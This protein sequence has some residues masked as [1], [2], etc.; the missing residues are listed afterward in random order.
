MSVDL[1]NRLRQQG[2]TI[3]DVC[4]VIVEF[5]L[6]K[7]ADLEKELNLKYGYPWNDSQDYRVIV[8]A[9]KESYKNKSRVWNGREFTKEDTILGGKIAGKKNL[10]S[11]H[12]HSIIN[13][14]AGGRASCQKE[15]TCPHCGKV[16]K[17]PSMFGWH[18]DKCKHKPINQM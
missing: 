7:A 4:E 6:D 2:Y 17:S 1:K 15:Y 8:K 3:D 13:P 12:W 14:S 5:D 11:G 10:E 9:S 18:F 16:G